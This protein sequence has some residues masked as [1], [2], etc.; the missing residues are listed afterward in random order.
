MFT[1]E[2]YK[3]YLE[4][5]IHLVDFKALNDLI[6]IGLEVQQ[7]QLDLQAQ[8]FED[9]EIKM[10]DEK[11]SKFKERMNQ[12]IQKFIDDLADKLQKVYDDFIN[13]NQNLKSTIIEI[14]DFKIDS[15][16]K[17]LNENLC[18][19]RI[20]KKNYFSMIFCHI[21]TIY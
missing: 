19:I 12:K 5:I 2:F 15:T 17:F 11:F 20:I 3:L 1:N 8:A 13:S 7:K 18:L 21:Y 9:W 10:I 4:N 14:P 16:I 6:N